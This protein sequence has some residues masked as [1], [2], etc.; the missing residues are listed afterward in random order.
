[1]TTLTNTITAKEIR[2]L[3]LKESDVLGFAFERTEIENNY[4]LVNGKKVLN[5]TTSRN[6]QKSHNKIQ[7]MC[8]GLGWQKP[9][10]TDEEKGLIQAVKLGLKLP[11]AIA[12][13]K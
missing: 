7:R 1:M 10:L 8:L 3:N 12:L 5:F 9:Q 2:T 4:L 6:R 11:K 13:Y